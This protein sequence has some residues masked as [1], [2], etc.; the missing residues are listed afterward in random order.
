[1]RRTFLRRSALCELEVANA[2]APV[3]LRRGL[4][5]LVGVVERAVVHRID[6]QIAVVSPSITRCTLTTC[7]IEKMLFSRQGVRRIS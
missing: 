4:V 7:A 5:V 6:G 1:M 3:E 2:S